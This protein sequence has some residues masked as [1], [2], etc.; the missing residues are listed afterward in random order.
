M[1]VFA[2]AHLLDLELDDAGVLVALAPEDDI[3][4]AA[5]AAIPPD[6]SPLCLAL[7]CRQDHQSVQLALDPPDRAIAGEELC[8]PAAVL[9]LTRDGRG[10]GVQN[11]DVRPKG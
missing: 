10:Q 11:R 2:V 3:G 4:V 6:A 1:T 5:K 7:M 8:R 9:V